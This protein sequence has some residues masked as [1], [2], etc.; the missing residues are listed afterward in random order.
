MQYFTSKK[1]LEP[2]TRPRAYEKYT[3]AL[4]ELSRCKVHLTKKTCD[5]EPE[6]THTGEGAFIDPR[7]SDNYDSVQRAMLAEE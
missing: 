1:S 7:Y 6:H 4:Q 5:D 2:A 3:K